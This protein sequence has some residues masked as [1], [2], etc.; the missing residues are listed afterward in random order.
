MAHFYAKFGEK[1]PLN[2]CYVKIE[3]L[4]ITEAYMKMESNFPDNWEM[5]GSDGAVDYIEKTDLKLYKTIY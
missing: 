3:A 4:D 2:G 1:H 5:V